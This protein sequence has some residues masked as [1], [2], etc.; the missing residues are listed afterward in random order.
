MHH[1]F[2]AWEKRF[3]GN[4]R[5]VKLARRMYQGYGGQVLKVVR[6]HLDL[7]CVDINH[8][9]DTFDSDE[10][11]YSLELYINT[12]DA[13]SKRPGLIMLELREWFDDANI[14][15]AAFGT[16]IC[17]VTSERGP[18]LEDGVYR[19]FMA[20]EH[21]ISMKTQVPNARFAS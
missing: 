20:F 19:G 12:R 5:L 13:Q 21:H 7:T 15:S 11:V 18:F 3:K 16:V 1:V 8:D 6:P 17:R 9:F 14:E 2:P 4:K 10:P